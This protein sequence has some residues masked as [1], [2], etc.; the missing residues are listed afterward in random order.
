MSALP[1]FG[2]ATGRKR[3][4]AL[5][6]PN[7]TQQRTTYAMNLADLV[8]THGYWV[9]GVGCFLEGETLLVLAGFAAHRGYLN[10]GAVIALAAVAGFAGDQAAFWLGRRHGAAM[11]A[12]FPSIERRAQQIQRLVTRYPSLSVIGVRFAYGLRIAGPVLMGT[13]ALSSAR[14]TALNALGAI[15]WATLLAAIGWFFGEAARVVLGE[16][17]HIEGW[18]YLGGLVEGLLVLAVLTARNRRPGPY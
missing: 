13:A 1:T 5:P 4:P 11:L 16:L 15:L 10:I 14:F 18:L 17:Q 12:R 8:G 9:L 3:T 6:P 7:N 2:G